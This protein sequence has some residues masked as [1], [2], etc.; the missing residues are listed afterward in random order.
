MD[1]KV[2]AGRSLFLPFHLMPPGPVQGVVPLW[3]EPSPQEVGWVVPLWGALS[4]Q[5]AG[6]QV[7]PSVGVPEDL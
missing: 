3:G 1:Y 6:W 7:D 4:L 2:F 5:V